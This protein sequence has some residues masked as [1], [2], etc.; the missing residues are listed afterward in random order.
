[1]NKQQ[2]L[3][4]WIGFFKDLLLGT[5]KN[6]FLFGTFS[7]KNK[8]QVFGLAFILYYLELLDGSGFWINHQLAL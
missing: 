6:L 7:Q 1:M 4:F 8:M 3:D 5:F 2:V